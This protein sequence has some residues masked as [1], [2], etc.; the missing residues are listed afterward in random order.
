MRTLSIVLVLGLAACGGEFGDL[1]QDQQPQIDPY[2]EA[3]QYGA[4]PSP[5]TVCSTYLGGFYLSW[6]REGCSHSIEAATYY[7]NCNYP[8]TQDFPQTYKVNGCLSSGTDFRVSDFSAT[9]KAGTTNLGCGSLTWT[10][11]SGCWQANIVMPGAGH[12]AWVT[13]A[14]AGPNHW[15]YYK[16]QA[17]TSNCTGTTVCAKAWAL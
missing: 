16:F 1:D 4:C 14:D 15:V 17:D 12:C 8:S 3:A 11:S 7:L 2:T 9:A 13:E 10:G 6:G 5:G